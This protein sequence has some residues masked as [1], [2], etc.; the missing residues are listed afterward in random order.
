MNISSLRPTLSLSLAAALALGGCA[1]QTELGTGG[2]MVSGSGGSAGSQGASNQ[3]VHCTSSLGTAALVEPD[4]QAA[5]LLTQVGLQSPL[6]LLRL[7]MAQSGC[8]RVVDRGAALRNMNQ[9][10]GL[11]QSGMLKNGS[12]T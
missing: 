7:I 6:P 12:A 10:V 8:F 5:T 1:S 11:A 3:M 9:E 2:S 4:A